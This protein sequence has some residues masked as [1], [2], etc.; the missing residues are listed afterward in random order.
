MEK[1]SDEQ[2]VEHS[3]RGKKKP[4]HSPRVLVICIQKSNFWL[5]IVFQTNGPLGRED[6]YV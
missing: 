2:V 4:G 6:F 5:S 3:R 1:E